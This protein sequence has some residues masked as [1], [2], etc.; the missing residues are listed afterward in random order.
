MDAARV[1]ET[2]ML[3][4]KE[5]QRYVNSLIVSACVFRLH[6]SVL[7][8]L[9]SSSSDLNCIPSLNVEKGALLHEATRQTMMVMMVAM[10]FMLAG[11]VTGYC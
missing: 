5:Y 7:S 9:H 10:L 8:R 1:C 3:L 11:M 4:D 2:K 6:D